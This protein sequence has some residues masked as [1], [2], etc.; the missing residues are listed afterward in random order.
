MP[1]A[2]AV[3]RSRWAELR[4]HAGF[5]KWQK[6]G[7]LDA[8]YLIVKVFGIYRVHEW[9]EHVKPNELRT[10]VWEHLRKLVDANYLEDHKLGY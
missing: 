7:C 3:L 5:P 4:A 1:W 9:R 2:R 10:L 6:G 8:A